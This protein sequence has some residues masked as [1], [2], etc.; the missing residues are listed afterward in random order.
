MHYQNL[1]RKRLTRAFITVLIGGLILALL[2]G[3]LG[4]IAVVH[5]AT[6]NVTNTNDSGPGSLRQAI[7]DANA[8]AGHDTI[9][10]GAGASGTI[11]LASTLPQIADDLT[12]S[13]PG[14]GVLSP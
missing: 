14:A 10:F 2:M 13:G 3:T 9:T 5:A 11:V 4:L 8:N 12:V 1:F 6:F 7:L